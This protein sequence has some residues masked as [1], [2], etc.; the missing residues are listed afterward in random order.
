MCLQD[1]GKEAPGRERIEVNYWP[2]FLK[3]VEEG[4]ASCRVEDESEEQGKSCL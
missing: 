2:K 4:G 1:D 3:K